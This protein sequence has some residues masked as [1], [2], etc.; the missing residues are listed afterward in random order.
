MPTHDEE[1]Q[2]HAL[3]DLTNRAKGGIWIYLIVWVAIGVIYQLPANEPGFFYLNL[4]IFILFMVLRSLHYLMVP[5]RQTF[6]APRMINILAVIVILA[7]IHWGI[8]V[9]WVISHDNYD[10]IRSVILIATPS[11]AIAGA[12]ALSISNIIRLFYAL[13]MYVPGTVV[14]FIMEN[15]EDQLFGFLAI[16]SIFYVLVTTAKVRDDYWTA[17]EGRLSAERRA[18]LMEEMSTTDPLT[19]LKNRM[20]F[21]KKFE[22]EW[23]RCARRRASISVLMIDLDYFK[24][25]ND[26][27]GHGFGDDYLIEVAKSFS[28]EIQREGDCLARYGG[29]EFVVLLPDADADSARQVAQRLISASLETKLDYQG[30]SVFCSCSIGGSTITPGQINK[31]GYLLQKADLALYEAKRNGRNRYCENNS[32]SES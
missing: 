9:A 12:V 21:D 25:I 2:K 19:K 32:H 14:L 6:D 15:K 29:E 20:Y 10:A 11:F 4:L 13:A 1:L 24:K 27:Y 8:M 31:S 5:R 22:A 3:I 17:L 23:K 28:A 18:D 26:T 16:I 30:E 7:A